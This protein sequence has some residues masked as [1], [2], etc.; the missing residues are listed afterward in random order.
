MPGPARRGVRTIRTILIR[1]TALVALLSACQVEPARIPR[2]I[3]ELLAPPPIPE[4]ARGDLGS[5]FRVR[6]EEVHAVVGIGI[7]FDLPWTEA[8]ARATGATPRDVAAGEPV[9]VVEELLLRQPDVTFPIDTIV[10]GLDFFIEIL[11]PRVEVRRLVIEDGRVGTLAAPWQAPGR[12]LWRM[13]DVD[14]TAV[15]IRIGGRDQ[16]LAEGFDIQRAD[17]VGEIRSRPI[18]VRSLALAVERNDRFVADAT[19]RLPETLVEA[20]FLAD[21]NNDWTTTLSADTFAFADLTALIPQLERA[22]P[23]GGAGVVTLSGGPDLH[24][25][26]VAWLRAESGRSRA[27]ARGGID[28]EPALRFRRFRAEAAPVHAG[29]VERVFG[30]AIPGGGEWSGWLA[31]DGAAR[32]RVPLRAELARTDAEGRIS[33]F[34]A[35]GDVVLVPEPYL[36]LALRAEPL[37]AADTAFAARLDLVGPADLLSVTGDVEIVGIDGLAATLDARLVDRPGAP[38]VFS[39]T[40]VVTAAQ[41]TVRRLAGFEGPT[42]PG[43]AI[44]AVAEGSVILAED[45]TIDVDIAADSLPL[46]LLPFPE[47]IDSVRGVVSGH[48]RIAGTVDAPHFRGRF[49]LDG[50]ALFVE[51]LRIAV[52]EI[53]AEARL[54]D[55]LLAVDTLGARAGG[56]DIAVTGTV[57]LFD[58][59]RRLDLDVKIDSVNIKDDEDGD[60]TASATLALEGPLERP[61]LTGRIFDLHGWIRE[62][63]FSPEPVL[64]LDDPPYADLA[65]R[66]PWPEDSELRRRGARERP[67]IDVHV[68]IEVDTAFTVL[69]E[70]SDLYGEGTVVVVTGEE[71]FEVHGTLDVL[72][73]F[74]AFFGE[75]FHVIGGTARFEGGVEPRIAIKAEYHE[76]WPIGAGRIATATEPG[77]FPPLEFLALGPAGRP[78]ERIT[79]WSLLPESQEELGALLI[80]DIE[81]LP[82]TGWRRRP[83]WRPSNPADLFDERSFTQS[84]ALLWSYSADEAYDYIPLDRGWLQAGTIETGPGYPAP[85]VVGPML[86]AGAIFDGFEVF[87]TQAL[88]GDFVPGVRVRANGFA[89]FGAKLEA[90]SVPRF[91]PAAP[92]GSGEP[93]FFVRRKTGV[94]FFWEWEFGPGGRGLNHRVRPDSRPSR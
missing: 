65:R 69:D 17:A 18:E 68:V 46:T 78:S 42:P 81:P 14:L 35:D 15:D 86:G 84:A 72:G 37:R 66:V 33:R 57:R 2:L 91:Y 4:S 38:A 82:V 25:I 74:Y 22:A 34:A 90:F 23:G 40:A 67:P 71:E 62:D 1:F 89:P 54:V 36:D 11:E 7:A 51:P 21:G 75:R 49:A 61:A 26:D 32:D 76:E 63:E 6:F 52:D 45:G 80:Y 29:D 10:T 24:A 31:G 43:E 16:G 77:R 87:V 13:R 27:L 59:P 73:G 60:V 58:G 93:G 56:G 5:A 39:G 79:R 70:D 50:G 30:V 9:V 64:D 55:G 12:W 19:V 47:A 92:G 41:E 8:V 94:G 28:I 85:I 83:V 53:A 3:P 44:V 48:G 20:E 88:Q